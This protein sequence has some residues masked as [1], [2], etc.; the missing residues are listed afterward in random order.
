MSSL[1]RQ[2]AKAEP[3][4][5][6]ACVRNILSRCEQDKLDLPWSALEHPSRFVVRHGW[7]DS[8]KCVI[9]CT[10]LWLVHEVLLERHGGLWCAF[11]WLG[12]IVDASSPDRH[13]YAIL[14]SDMLLL[15]FG[16]SRTEGTPISVENALPLHM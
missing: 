6:L 8:I 1:F 14:F 13:V 5:R 11:T 9:D 12:S 10:A 4:Y 2:A 15:G 7:I 16:V 3:A